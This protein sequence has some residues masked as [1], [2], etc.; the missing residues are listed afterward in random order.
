MKKWTLGFFFSSFEV[1]PEP[2]HR[3]TVTEHDREPCPGWMAP[4]RVRSVGH[5]PVRASALGLV[6]TAVDCQ[7]TRCL[8]P[9][10]TQRG[11]SRS[12]VA[13]TATLT[14]AA[15]RHTH[16]HT[17]WTEMLVSLPCVLRWLWES[18]DAQAAESG[19]LTVQIETAIGPHEPGLYP[20]T[21]D[22]EKTS[23]VTYTSLCQ[24]C[25]DCSSPTS[26]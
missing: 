19:N 3:N 14:Q 4:R 16:A 8:S 2:T 18:H 23:W 21:A 1:L 10:A 5:L 17:Q 9:Y 7:C 12:V 11:G 26:A 22:A 25:A 24:A 6:P 13:E 15:Q 20:A